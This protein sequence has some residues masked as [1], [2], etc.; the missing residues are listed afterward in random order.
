VLERKLAADGRQRAG[1]ERAGARETGRPE[2]SRSVVATVEQVVDREGGA[3]RGAQLVDGLMLIQRKT[4]VI[5]T[6]VLQK[7][8]ARS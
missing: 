6:D 1:D 7:P 3:I 8:V 2:L 5:E 4:R